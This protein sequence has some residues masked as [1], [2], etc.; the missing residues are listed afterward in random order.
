MKGKQGCQ[1]VAPLFHCALS[2][3]LSEDVGLKMTTSLYLINVED[4]SHTVYFPLFG[5]PHYFA[6]QVDI[7]FPFVYAW[8]TGCKGS[9]RSFDREC[10]WIM[11]MWSHGRMM[12][13][14]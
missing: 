14:I 3:S 9:W 7:F 13:I 8:M 12:I 1:V 4:A 10:I 2:L 11:E 5:L 6:P